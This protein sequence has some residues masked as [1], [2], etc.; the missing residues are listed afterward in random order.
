MDYMRL[1]RV[2]LQRTHRFSGTH[3]L[4][5]NSLFFLLFLFIVLCYNH[6]YSRHFILSFALTPFSPSSSF[7]RFRKSSCRQTYRVSTSSEQRENCLQI[8]SEIWTDTLTINSVL[9]LH[10][11]CTNLIKTKN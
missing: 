3:F 11:E 8:V 4:V 9:G 10:N 2:Y 1:S 6:Y 5:S 7:P